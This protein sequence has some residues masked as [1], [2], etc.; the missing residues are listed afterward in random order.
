[1]PQMAPLLW[2]YLYVIFLISLILFLTMNF[3][4]KPFENINTSM[5]KTIITKKY[6]KL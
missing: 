2:L 5:D 1:M 3:Y 6:W 4:I